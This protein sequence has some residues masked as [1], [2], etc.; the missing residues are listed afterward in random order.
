LNVDSA[1]SVA[2]A[3]NEKR[4]HDKQR[5]HSRPDPQPSNGP[6]FSRAVRDAMMAQLG[7]QERSG[8]R[9]PQ[10]RV[11]RRGSGCSPSQCVVDSH[12]VDVTFTPCS[13]E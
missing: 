1:R 13:F 10:P 2:V 12:S 7:R 5:S 6:G 3:S 9:R 8:P 11:G 4:D